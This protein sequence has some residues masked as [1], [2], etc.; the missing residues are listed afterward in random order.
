MKERYNKYMMDKQPSEDFIDQ[1]KEKMQCELRRKKYGRRVVVKGAVWIAAVVIVL[2]AALRTLFGSSEILDMP[3]QEPTVLTVQESE[4]PEE[5]RAQ[6]DKPVTADQ[7]DSASMGIITNPITNTS[8]FNHDISLGVSNDY[9]VASGFS[10]EGDSRY[11]M[12]A[13]FD[14]ITQRCI[15]YLDYSV[16]GFSGTFKA[17]AVIDENNVLAIRSEDESFACELDFISD[18]SVDNSIRLPNLSFGI[19]QS[20]ERI[21]INSCPK[22]KQTD[23]DVFD[24]KGN[25]LWK[26]SWDESIR[27]AGVEYDGL[28]YY[29]Y[30]YRMENEENHALV[31]CLS[32]NGD[33]NWRYDGGDREA[34]IK[35]FVMDTGELLLLGNSYV[36]KYNT[37]L[38]KLKDGLSEW[39]RDFFP[40][41]VEDAALGQATTKMAASAVKHKDGMIVALNMGYPRA[42]SIALRYVSLDGDIRD[43]W[44]EDFPELNSCTDVALA[45]REG[46][47]YLSVSGSVVELAD[48]G[49]EDKGDDDLIIADIPKHIFIKRVSVPE[50]V[51]AE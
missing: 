11:P 29:A 42:N 31:M 46:N 30:G 23:L 49:W 40:S 27:F 34:F 1:L 3:K 51:S 10:R 41:V 6:V 17:A 50:G 35:A 39:R 8:A 24:A 44:I 43:E 12:Y 18:G 47:V 38:F 45:S 28:N 48:W 36:K 22:A 19:F 5:N 4:G 9:F 25:W 14:P 7:S 20:N 21:F 33:I 32:E 37:F 15:N 16:E 26:M 2:F 13:V